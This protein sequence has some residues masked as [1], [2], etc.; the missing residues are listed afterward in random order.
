MVVLYQ[1]LSITPSQL[2]HK[3]F[4]SLEQSCVNCQTEEHKLVLSI[5][6]CAEVPSVPALSVVFHLHLLNRGMREL[7]VHGEIMINS[8]LI[9]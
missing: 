5:L 2:P 9:Q 4:V 6:H 8:V 3:C 7:Y 1:L